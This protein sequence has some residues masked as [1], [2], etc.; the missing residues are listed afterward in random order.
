MAEQGRRGVRPIQDLGAIQMEEP[1]TPDELRTEQAHQIIDAN[2]YM[3]LGTADAAGQPWASPV[4]FAHHDYREF[5]WISSPEVRHSR[6]IAERPRIGVVI[7]DSRV[8]IGTG[9]GVYLTCEAAVA[10][11]ADVDRILDVFNVRSLASGGKALA[12]SDVKGPFASF[13]LYRA[14]AEEASMLAKDGHADHRVPVRLG[15]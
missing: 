2:Q 12:R 14:V 11:D 7:F 6:S 10:S 8:P 5:V 9:Q 3:V 4:W 13:R 15:P 1:V